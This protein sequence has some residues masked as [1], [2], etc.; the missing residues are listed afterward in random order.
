MTDADNLFLSIV[1]GAIG[2][3]YFVYGK[4]NARLIP[5]LAGMGLCGFPYFISSGLA[6]I[7]VGGGLTLAPWFLRQDS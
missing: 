2:M 7:L 4:K 5:L 1:F 3:G 6:M